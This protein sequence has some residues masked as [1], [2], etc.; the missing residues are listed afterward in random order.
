MARKGLVFYLVM[1]I[2]IVSIGYLFYYRFYC[3]PEIIDEKEIIDFYKKFEDKD[4]VQLSKKEILLQ[5]ERV[6]IKNV[7]V[8]D[9]EKGGYM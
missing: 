6:K 1:S 7:P 4:K 8:Q 9:I 5:S 3:M 2:P